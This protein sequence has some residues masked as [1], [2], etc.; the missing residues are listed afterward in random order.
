MTTV[1]PNW[2]TAQIGDLRGQRIVV[3]G[4]NSG[5]GFHTALEL[6]RAG[7]DVIVACRDNRRGEDALAR[8]RDA[9]PQASFRLEQLDLADL[10][11]VRAFAERFLATGVSLDVLINNA[12]VMAIPTRELTVDGFERQFGTNVLG[13][14]ALTGLLLQALRRSRAPRVVTLSSGTAYFGRLD[15]DNLQS[16]KRYSASMTYAQSKLANLLFMRE[17]GR[18]APWLLSVAA[19]PGATHT[20]LQQHTGL[21]TKITMSFLGQPAEAGALPS[22]YSAV[23][24]VESGEFFGPSRKFNMN[25]APMRVRMPKRADAAQSALAL[26]RASERLTGV[27]FDGESKHSDGHRRCA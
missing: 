15:L 1:T 16:E 14:F 8:M 6:G 10:K 22:L 5:I 17:L 20:N 4:A 24:P 13:H 19:H 25:G 26:W 12:G 2:T 18:R 9:A 3:T 23:G 27:T 21:F 11:S 7:A